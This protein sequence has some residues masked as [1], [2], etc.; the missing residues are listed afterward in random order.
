MKLLKIYIA[1]LIL[2]SSQL[3]AESFDVQGSDLLM[4][5]GS[6]DIAR[7]GAST[8]STNDLY[9]IFYNPAGLSE[10]QTAQLALSAQAD[11]RLGYVNFFGMAYAFAVE[12][13]SLKIAVA[14]A[15]IP[16]LYVKTSGAFIEDDFESIFLRYT[17]PDLS[18]NFDGDIDS[19]TDDYRFAIAFTP[20]YNPSWS[21]GVSVG[22][23]NCATT[24]AGV[25][26]EDPSNFTYMSTV[27]KATA[28]GIGAKYYINEDI[29]VGAS[30]KNIDAKLAVETQIID[31]N[32]ERV[33]NYDV[34]F[35]YDF[36]V[37]IDYKYD[38]DIKL[39]ADYQEVQGNYGDFDIDFKMLRFGTTLSSNVL[40]YHFGAIA[41][42]RLY[43]SKVENLELPYPIVPTAGLGWHNDSIDVSAAFYIHPIMSLHLGKPSPSL[44]LSIKYD[45]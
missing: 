21:L 43:S 35:P 29:K 26:L 38:E 45:F 7:A 15:Y 5:I 14:F 22:Y 19:K 17:L 24:F 34:D 31:D 28:F 3:F 30:L 27:A 9:A 32:G 36:S 37:G 4:G 11:A 6:T 20:L 1:P 8:A 44:D 42:L 13:L 23:V 16:R 40:D 18:P 25:T 39:A 33:K 41:P 10:I 12:P 2:F